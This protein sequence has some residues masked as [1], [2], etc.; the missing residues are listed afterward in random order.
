MPLLHIVHNGATQLIGGDLHS[1]AILRDKINDVINGDVTT[2]T[3][4]S[5]DAKGDVQSIT[6]QELLL[7]DNGEVRPVG[8]NADGDFEFDMLPE[9]I[10][11]FDMLPEGADPLAFQANEQTPAVLSSDEV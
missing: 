6:V 9:D 4:Q 11:E 10:F 5:T 7:D 2:I 1:L 8:G 3:F